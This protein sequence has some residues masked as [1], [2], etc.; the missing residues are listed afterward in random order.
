[1]HF[2]IPLQA[3]RPGEMVTPFRPPTLPARRLAAGTPTPRILA[4]DDRPESRH[5]LVRLLTPLGFEVREAANGQEAIDVWR[6][7]QPQLILMDMRMPVLDGRE[8]TRRIRAAESGGHTCIVALT[9]SSFE[10]ERTEILA[11]GCDDFL[12]KPF[13]EKDLLDMLAH[14]LGLRYEYDTV[15]PG[16]QAEEPVD[17]CAGRLGSLPQPL[18]ERLRGAVSTLDVKSMEEVLLAIRRHDPDTAAMLAPLAERFDYQRIN[19]LLDGE[20]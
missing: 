9:A 16:R 15:P 6:Q 8:A 10:E 3:A 17:V 12:R 14:H 5:L 7:W 11:N 1:V 20:P 18:R 4:V 19:T 13:R 2:D